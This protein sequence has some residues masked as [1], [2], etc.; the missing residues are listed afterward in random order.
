MDEEITIDIEIN[1]IN[2]TKNFQLIGSKEIDTLSSIATIK[3][4]KSKIINTFIS[5]ELKKNNAKNYIKLSFQAKPGMISIDHMINCFEY[6]NDSNF[7]FCF[8]KDNL[9]PYLIA[10]TICDLKTLRITILDKILYDLDEENIPLIIQTINSLNE[11]KLKEYC[12]YLIKSIINKNY[13]LSGIKYDTYSFDDIIHYKTNLTNL[14]PNPISTT[15]FSFEQNKLIY[16]G[17]N[18]TSKTNILFL[19]EINDNI[20]NKLKKFY[21]PNNYFNTGKVIKKKSEESL[22]TSSDYPHYYHMIL[23]N[24]T[25]LNLYAIRESENS[26]F[27]I[28]CNKNDYTKYGPNYVGEV[29]ANFWGTGFTVYDNGYEESMKG[30][31]P[32]SIM[33]IRKNF[34]N[35]SYETNIMGEC[36]RFFKIGLILSDGTI[37]KFQN[38][39]PRWSEKMQ[40]YCLNFYGRVK[41]ASAK[42]FQ[43]IRPNETDDILLQHGKF[44]KMEYSIDFR[45]PFSPLFAFAISLVSIGKKR[46]VS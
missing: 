15:N 10:F 31:I 36:P 25:N 45:D 30:Y 26:N 9:I 32:N 16:S 4:P 35:I 24:D 1:Y 2:T 29:V 21:E 17:E 46:V 12:F 33:N 42:N 7:D 13:H 34:G 28:S 14:I 22:I 3:I 39:K 41:K 20:Y 44:A 27:I 18:Q 38:V 8:N 11:N 19:K 37:E 6:F 43:I 40:C 5:N 23:E